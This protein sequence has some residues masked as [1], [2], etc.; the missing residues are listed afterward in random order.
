MKRSLTPGQERARMKQRHMTMLK[1]LFREY[2]E[3][4]MD[5]TMDQIEDLCKLSGITMDQVVKSLNKG[6]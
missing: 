3:S 4:Y 2:A 6:K 1:Q 5:S